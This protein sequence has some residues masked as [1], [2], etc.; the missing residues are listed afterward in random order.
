MFIVNLKNGE[1]MKFGREYDFKKYVERYSQKVESTEVR[2]NI[3]RPRYDNVRRPLIIVG[4]R[5]SY[6]MNH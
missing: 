3:R 4:R 2:N 5:M 6:G 1:T